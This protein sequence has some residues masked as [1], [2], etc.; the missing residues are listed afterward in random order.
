MI[1]YDGRLAEKFKEYTE[2][3]AD[4]ITVKKQLELHEHDLSGVFVKSS[5]YFDVK[6]DG[7]VYSAISVG[8]Y[9]YGLYPYIVPASWP[10]NCRTHKLTCVED[11]NNYRMPDIG[12]LQ[13]YFERRI[14]PEAV[15]PSDILGDNAYFDRSKFMDSPLYRLLI[16]YRDRMSK[17]KGVQPKEIFTVMRLC[18]FL[19]TFPV[20]TADYYQIDREV[21]EDI[22]EIWGNYDSRN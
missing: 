12:H 10:H 1:K 7:V 17:I 15:T 21:Q 22:L 2:R 14:I 3:Y 8:D 4:V 16:D 18:N 13:E 20:N 19:T 5:F 9:G 11:V 6:L